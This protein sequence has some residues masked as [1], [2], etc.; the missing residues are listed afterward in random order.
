MPSSASTSVEAD[1]SFALDVLARLSQPLVELQ[2]ASPVSRR[3]EGVAAASSSTADDDDDEAESSL[4][5]SLPTSSLST[6]NA[7]LRILDQLSQQQTQSRTFGSAAPADVELAR[8]AAATAALVLDALLRDAR[9]R[10]AAAW[11]WDEIASDD[12]RATVYLVQSESSL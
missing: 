6:P 9:S 10:D 11:A 7:L 2:L 4:T 8:V 12:W 1:S 3:E 5:A